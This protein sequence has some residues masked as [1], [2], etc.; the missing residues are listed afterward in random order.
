MITKFRKKPVVIEAVKVLNNEYAD[1]PYTFEETPDWL[2]DAIK[3][4]TVKAKFEGEDYW[5]LYISTL[6]GDMRS[7]PGDW[8]V[9]GV[10]GELYPVRGDIFAE[11]YEPV[12]SP[13]VV[14]EHHQ[15]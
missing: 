4:G 15:I 12:E 10:K 9:R 5:Y 6:E 14:V 13:A 11:T 1:N 8:I 7:G 2:A 3:D